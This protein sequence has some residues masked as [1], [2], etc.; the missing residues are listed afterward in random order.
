MSSLVLAEH[1]E[2]PFGWEKRLLSAGLEASFL[3]TGFWGNLLQLLDKARPI[4][5]EV[6]ARNEIVASLMVMHLIPYDR[7]TGREARNIKSF[8]KGKYGGWLEFTG[9]PTFYGPGRVD[10]A[11]NLILAWIS[12]YSR[13]N[14]L[15]L[16]NMG[17]LSPCSQYLSNEKV[18]EVFKSFGYYRRP[19]A[20]Y[21]VDL[22][23][24]VDTL[25]MNLAHS[26]RKGVKRSQRLE[27]SV[28]CVKTWNEYIE[29][30]LA[31]YKLCNKVDGSKIPPLSVVKQAWNQPHYNDFYQYYVA[32]NSE[33]QTLGVLGMS[34]FNGVATEIMSARTPEAFSRKIPAQDILHWEMF[35]DAKRMGCHTF[36]MGGVNPHPTNSKEAGIKRFKA[37][38]GGRYVEYGTYRKVFRPFA[39]RLL[40]RL[41]RWREP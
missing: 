10:E 39:Y 12:N 24:D 8:L 36:D 40:A 37:K 9:G 5:L 32:V 2:A 28:E 35:L 15:N 25:W 27:V 13:N 41:K 19:W 17:G 16:I 6:K 11:L 23:P 22:T 4:F 3:Q 7:H 1:S 21:L 29:K 33:G 38:F 26:A 18:A 30:F 31:P 34:V 20:T 14:K